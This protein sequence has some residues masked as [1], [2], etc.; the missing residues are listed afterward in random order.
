MKDTAWLTTF[1]PIITIFIGSVFVYVMYK[2]IQPKNKNGTINS[3]MFLRNHQKKIRSRAKNFSYKNS[4]INNNIKSSISLFLLIILSSFTIS[5]INLENI[6]GAVFKE[7]YE[8]NSDLKIQFLFI[9]WFLILSAIF[10]ILG[11]RYL[12]SGDK[13]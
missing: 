7:S 4:I 1:I 9:V 11:T 13:K 3:N 5:Y 2:I 10:I 6:Y 8:V 12:L